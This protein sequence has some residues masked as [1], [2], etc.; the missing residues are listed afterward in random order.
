MLLLIM[1]P[2]SEHPNRRTMELRKGRISIPGARYFVTVCLQHAGGNLTAPPAGRHLAALIPA[3]F[4]PPDASLLCATLMPD[5]LHLLLALGHRLS[6]ERL[7][8]KFKAQ[9]RRMLPPGTA[10]QR[11][12][13]E[14]RLRPDEPANDYARYIYLNPYR[15]KLVAPDA[16]WL[17]WMLGPN[18]DFD[19]LHQLNAGGCPP[20][21]WLEDS[22]P[23]PS[24]LS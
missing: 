19:F 14:H 5:H 9:S 17:H 12:F 8:A 23:L 20:R 6:I 16:R 4:A 1:N 11:N 7:V 3:I 24:G 18:A 21:S 10:W 22:E 2:P 15:K 13:F